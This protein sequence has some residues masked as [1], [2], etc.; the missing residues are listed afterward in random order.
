MI[1]SA[2]SFPDVLCDMTPAFREVMS[3]IVLLCNCFL[4]LEN[5]NFHVMGNSAKATGVNTFSIKR[6]Y[7][8]ITSSF[9]KELSLWVIL[10]IALQVAWV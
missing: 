1:A 6:Q 10:Y 9:I 8:A 4:W 2:I 7:V 5:P 3:S